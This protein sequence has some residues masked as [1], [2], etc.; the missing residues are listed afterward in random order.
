MDDPRRSAKRAPECVPTTPSGDHAF[1]AGQGRNMLDGA[2]PKWE[3]TQ[4]ENAM[5]S[6]KLGGGSRN[7]HIHLYPAEFDA[8]LQ[9][10]GYETWRRDVSGECESPK[11]C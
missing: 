3:F 7:C 10:A 2:A 11:A 6:L 9:A 1:Y 5:W 4:S 8:L